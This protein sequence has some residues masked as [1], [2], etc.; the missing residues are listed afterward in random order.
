MAVFLGL[1]LQKL[2]KVESKEDY[3]YT[4]GGIIWK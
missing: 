3:L 1:Y 4:Y 2:I